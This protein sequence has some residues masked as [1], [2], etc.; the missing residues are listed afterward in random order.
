MEKLNTIINQLREKVEN[1]FNKDASGHNIDH[2]ERTLNY[3]VYLQSQ[4]REGDLLVIGISAFIHD[5]HRIMGAEQNRLI[6][7][8]PHARCCATF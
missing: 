8:K 6:I 3:A 1:Y 5:I 4:E 2:L 7:W